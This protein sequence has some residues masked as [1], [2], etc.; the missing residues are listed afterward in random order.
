MEEPVG[1]AQS[2]HPQL[3]TVSLAQG[4]GDHDGLILAPLGLVD[5]Q[6]VG[7]PHEFWGLLEG[8]WRYNP[9]LLIERR[10]AYPIESQ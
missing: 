5:G 8:I 3:L 1:C 10:K 4:H 6:R 2:S 7:E 9:I